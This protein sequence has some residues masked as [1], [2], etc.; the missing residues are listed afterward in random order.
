[1]TT[2]DTSVASRSLDIH[3]AKLM[4]YTIELR[5]DSVLGDVWR[6]IRPDG[7]TASVPGFL[8]D[9]SRAWDY[10]PYFSSDRS[11]AFELLSTFDTFRMYRGEDCLSVSIDIWYN[12]ESCWRQ[13]N[14]NGQYKDVALLI[15]Q[16]VIKAKG[17]L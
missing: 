15:C 2:P 1:M 7:T 5:P 16:V 13:F 14:A 3:V 12:D 10:V 9:E 11:A 4:G 6:L 8:S 17:S